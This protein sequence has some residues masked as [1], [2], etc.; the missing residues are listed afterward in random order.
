MNGENKSDRTLGNKG[1]LGETGPQ[2]PLP[3]SN[4]GLGQHLN[5]KPDHHQARFSPSSTISIPWTLLQDG[6]LI[7]TVTYKEMKTSHLG[8][9]SSFLVMWPSCAGVNQSLFPSGPP[10]PPPTT[11]DHVQQMMLAGKQEF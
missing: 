10:C 5:L 7:A 9:Q 2:G 11:Y 8:T 6:S 4:R 1:T 3:A